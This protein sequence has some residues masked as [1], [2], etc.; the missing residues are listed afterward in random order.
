M[1]SRPRLIHA[2]RHGLR[3]QRESVSGTAIPIAR[4]VAGSLLAGLPATA[5]AIGIA[6]PLTDSLW[7]RKPWRV[8]WINLGREV[9]TLVAAYGAY[10]TILR[11]L[12]MVVDGAP[13]PIVNIE[14]LPVLAGYA[15]AYF[16]FGRVL[17]Y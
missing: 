13:I 6:V 1:T 9:I 17:F 2:T 10:A 15:L 5:L 8:A 12:G 4:A 14:L 7:Q 11:W 16:M 3:C